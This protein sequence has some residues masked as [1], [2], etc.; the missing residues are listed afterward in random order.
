[1][2]NK[3]S[4]NPEEL[5]SKLYILMGAVCLVLHTVI[6]AYTSLS[7]S[8]SG[9]IFFI[10]YSAGV[11]AVYFFARKRILFFRAES[12]ASNE[13][14]TGVIRTF[15]ESVGVPYAV[16]NR[17]NCHRQRRNEKVF[18]KRETLYNA[19]IFD[20]ASVTLND[21]PSAVSPPLPMI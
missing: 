7:P 18:G 14:N 1:M 17:K 5:P 4:V 9:L 2:K 20:L 13:Q 19:N 6:S 11:C 3:F 16:V 12:D 15:K 10:I 21:L 8:L